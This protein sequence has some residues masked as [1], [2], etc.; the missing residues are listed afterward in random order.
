[1]RPAGADAAGVKPPR[2]L[3]RSLRPLR[4]RWMLLVQ[5]GD[6]DDDDRVIFTGSLVTGNPAA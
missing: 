2:R 3:L 5:P 6:D 4:R 1:M